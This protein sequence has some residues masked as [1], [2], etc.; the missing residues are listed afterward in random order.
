MVALKHQTRTRTSYDD[1][2][3]EATMTSVNMNYHELATNWF[4][5]YLLA[6]SGEL[7]SF[8]LEHGLDGSNGCAREYSLIFL[9]HAECAESLELTYGHSLKSLLGN[10]NCSNKL[11]LSF[12]V[13]NKSY[14]VDS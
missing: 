14:S 7:A 8:E 12:P 11:T 6:A 13:Y 4:I 10:T 5:N 3:L 2:M 1:D 9:W